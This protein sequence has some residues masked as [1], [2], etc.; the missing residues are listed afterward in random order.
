MS[1]ACRNV[2]NHEMMSVRNGAAY[3]CNPPPL[4]FTAFIQ[5]A[6]LIIRKKRCSQEARGQWRAIGISPT[7][8]LGR[9]IYDRGNM[10]RSIALLALKGFHGIAL[11]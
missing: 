10:E 2:V 5:A 1:Q 7:E 4:C 8:D 11:Q 9:G 6:S 3:T